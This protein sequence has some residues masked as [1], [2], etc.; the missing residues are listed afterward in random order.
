MEDEAQL[1]NRFSSVNISKFCE[2]H[3]PKYD[4][5]KEHCSKGA[6]L[7]FRLTEQVKLLEKVFNTF[8]LGPVN[9]AG[10]F[11]A[12]EQ[13]FIF[14][15]VFDCIKSFSVQTLVDWLFFQVDEHHNQKVCSHILHRVHKH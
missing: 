8:I 13:F 6:S 4:T 2:G 15:L 10:V 9:F 1:I 7:P 14:L 11:V 12:A 3:A 5:K